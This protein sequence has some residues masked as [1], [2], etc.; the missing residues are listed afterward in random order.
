MLTILSLLLITGISAL[1]IWTALT[2]Q[3]LTV[4]SLLSIGE[5]SVLS[6][7]FSLIVAY[8]YINGIGAVRINFLHLNIGNYLADMFFFRLRVIGGIVVVKCADIVLVW[9]PVAA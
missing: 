7:S 2:V 3:G 9:Y 6:D 4:L 8:F 5:I 1:I